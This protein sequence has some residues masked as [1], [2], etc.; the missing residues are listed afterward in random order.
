MN[1]T[2]QL[3][4]DLPSLY[5]TPSQPVKKDPK[6]WERQKLEKGLNDLLE[7][8]VWPA[9]NDDSENLLLFID[10]VAHNRTWI[11]RN[12]EVTKKIFQAASKCLGNES[13]AVPAEKIKQIVRTN[14]QNLGGHL[15]QDIQFLVGKKVVLDSALAFSAGSPVFDRLF[16]SNFNDRLGSKQEVKIAGVDP[17]VFIYF[18]HFMQYGALLK[19]DK[20]TPEEVVKLIDYAEEKMALDAVLPQLKP[21]LAGVQLDRAVAAHLYFK[22]DPD[23]RKCCFISLVAQSENFAQFKELLDLMQKYDSSESHKALYQ[24]IDRDI[25]AAITL[26]DVQNWQEWADKLSMK[27]IKRLC[28]D[29]V[30]QKTP[31]ESAY[32]YAKHD[33][34][35]ADRSDVRLERGVF[36]ENSD[37]KAYFRDGLIEQAAGWLETLEHKWDPAKQDSKSILGKL[38]S[39]KNKEEAVRNLKE[40]STHLPTFFNLTNRA[41]ERF[42]ASEL[43]WLLGSLHHRSEEIDLSGSKLT[44]LEGLDR[45][46]NL[47]ILNLQGCKQ[48]TVD[49][50]LL[51]DLS[52]LQI[53]NIRAIEKDRIMNRDKCPTQ[54]VILE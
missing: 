17:Q 28:L 2:L 7:K 29:R 19:E 25:P 37:K 18:A 8:G 10:S 30:Y 53:V 52:K 34:M 42:T 40:F 43:K 54:C 6:T 13:L 4:Q 31:L 12:H 35:P 21:F 15:P 32:K 24:Q 5:V 26:H 1:P 11:N 39:S 3:P 14:I 49:F 46:A 41:L 33:Y 27:R 23:L 47:R 22:P 44:N 38:F 51:S 48:L 50:G 45:F 20:P 9:T 36:V 16:Y